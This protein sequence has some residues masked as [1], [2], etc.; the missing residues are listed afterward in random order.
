MRELAAGICAGDRESAEKR[1]GLASDGTSCGWF[2][3]VGAVAG[4]RLTALTVLGK[5]PVLSRL[6]RFDRTEPRLV[7]AGRAIC[8]VPGSGVRLIWGWAA[9]RR[10]KFAAVGG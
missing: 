6:A 9:I 5:S 7:K 8:G 10:F 2:G 4:S 1:V 3:G